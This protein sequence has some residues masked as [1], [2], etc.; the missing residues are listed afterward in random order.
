MEEKLRLIKSWSQRFD[1]LFDPMVKKLESLRHYLDHDMPK[2]VSYLMQVQRTLDDYMRIAQ[3][4][5][6]ASPKGA[7]A[8]P[9]A[10]T[11]LNAAT[12]GQSGS[13]VSAGG[14][15]AL[16]FFGLGRTKRRSGGSAS[17]ATA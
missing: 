2:S 11:P 9:D 15:G 12:A 14:L 17:F 5:A 3:P 4:D 7:T 1:S 16:G 13:I 6:S 10:P 8:A